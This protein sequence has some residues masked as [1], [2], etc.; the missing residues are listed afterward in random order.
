M[1][2]GKR[3]SKRVQKRKTDYRGRGSFLQKDASG[4]SRKPVGL[5]GDHP[6]SVKAKRMIKGF[7]RHG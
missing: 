5:Q 4:S 3:S 2:Y 7:S 6:S 1:I